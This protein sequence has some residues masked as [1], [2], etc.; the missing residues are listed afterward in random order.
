MNNHLSSLAT[1]RTWSRRVVSALFLAGVLAGATSCNDDSD[2][3][4][5]SI[6]L[7]GPKPEWGPTIHPEMQTVIEKLDQLSGGVPLNTLTP[8][9]AR[10]APSATDAVMAVMRDYNIPAPV[11]QVD[12]T[13]QRI[14]VSG[15]TIRVRIYR[16]KNATGN[17]PA[18]VY[19]HG[20]GWV[21]AN[22]N[23]YDPSA[24][25]LSEQ[26]GA[27]VV[28]V[29]YRQAPE[30]KF[31]TAHNDS[32]AAYRW[33]RDNATTLNINAQ[34]IAVAGESAG[35][36]LAGAVCLMARSASVPLPVH[37]LLVYPI[38]RYDMNTTSYTQ[39]ANAKPLSKPLM[40]WF[41]DKYL[42]SS[43]DGTNPLIS[44]VNAT[45]L[46][47][48]PPATVINAEIDPLQSEGQEYASKLK[49]AGVSVTSK[50][51]EG[52]THEFFG[53]ATVVPEAR[54]AQALA[55]SELKKSLQ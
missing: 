46:G 41:Y 27:V 42:T 36:N 35:G 51:Y 32:F 29:A 15:G 39:Y 2:S 9:Q 25:A 22:L 4:S 24:R 52:V 54:E 47:S 14:P 21:I 17:L 8:Q 50:V 28:S 6:K 18:I 7:A 34:R 53:M 23:T 5:T 30:F 12:T 33:V 40:Q 1:A 55:A 16:P 45:N 26:T 38:A 3:D 37:Q 13:G 49:A 10:M 19:Y 48:L 31:P 20:G 44:L 11:P 43:A